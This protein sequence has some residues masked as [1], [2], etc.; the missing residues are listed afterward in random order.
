MRRGTD[1]LARSLVSSNFGDARSSVLMLFRIM[2]VCRSLT[3]RDIR[4]LP[5]SSLQISS[6]RLYLPKIHNDN[7]NAESEFK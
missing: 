6:L 3:M 7:Y 5:F 1:Y 2:T 4:I